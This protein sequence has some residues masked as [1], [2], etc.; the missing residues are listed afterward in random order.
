MSLETEIEPGNDWLHA[1]ADSL[2]WVMGR[3]KPG[4]SRAQ[5]ESN[6][7]QIANQLAHTYPNL[8]APNT[9]FHLTAPGLIGNRLRK[10][11][12]GFGIVL[13][14][15]AAAGLL[16]ACVNLA[17]MLLARAADRHR[18]IGIRLAVGATKF[19]LL[20][21]LMT[22]SLLLAAIGGILGFATADIACRL[23][24]S[25]HP[26]IDLPIRTVLY[27]DSAV[28]WFTAA[29][30]LAATILFGLVPALQAMGTDVIPSLKNEP[31]SIRLRRWS[32]RDVLATGQIALSVILV[33]C[34]VLVV[35]SLQHALSLNLGFNPN[36]AVSVSFDLR[37]KGYNQESSR[38]FDDTLLAKASEL[39]GIQYAGIVDF[40]P[41]GGAGSSNLISRGDRP[42]PKPSERQWAWLYNISPGYLQAAGTHLLSGRDID[43][44]DRE[45]ATRVALVNEALARLLY[46]KADPL[47]KYVRL[48][49]DSKDKGLEIIGVVETGKYLS[50]GEDPHA[51]V[52]LPIAQVGT[53]WTT[54]V[55]RTL[56]PPS[57][58]I[59]MLRKTILDL[60]PDLALFNAGSLKEQLAMPLFPARAAAIVL[61]VFGVIAMILAATG[62]FALMA[63]S[64]SRRTHEIGIRMALGAQPFQ[65]VSSIF[66]RTLL[67][68]AI[69]ISLGTIVTLVAGKL[70]SAILYGFSPYD[71][72]S[73]IIA[74][75]LMT[76]VAL[77][78]S[79]NPATRAIRID[80]AHSLREQ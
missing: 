31:I 43:A 14:S 41:L 5:A 12:A 53:G 52:F 65:V 25:W 76:A 46:G 13:T 71:P 77:A 78:A 64:V 50:L 21:Q 42:L 45:G 60:N 73:Y 80:P 37:M 74:L 49:S 4:V 30:A 59:A 57:E 67:L 23:F 48:G 55:A 28:L 19:Q 9:K 20:C 11:I 10:P 18:E 68:C 3:L 58:A 22:E 63:Y 44:H 33:I 24:S 15:L 56:L 51:A 38:R 69:G 75:L 54:L 79:W 7:D 35:R 47:G 40:L 32:V 70:L 39:P 62:L 36:N 27:P 61:G 66:G 29:V 6:L 16:L 26:N 72:V 34:S 2:I 8:L 1:R 17:G